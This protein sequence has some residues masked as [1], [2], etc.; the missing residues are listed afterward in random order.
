MNE[1]VK[2]VKLEGSQD[3]EQKKKLLDQEEGI[4]NP[5]PPEDSAKLEVINTFTLL[6]HNDLKGVS[7]QV[8]E[9]IKNSHNR[10]HESI[11][12]LHDIPIRKALT[13]EFRGS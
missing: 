9:E 3:A 11:E 8:L 12:S 10:I 5:S 7:A 1:D 6:V 4:K 13:Q 2:M